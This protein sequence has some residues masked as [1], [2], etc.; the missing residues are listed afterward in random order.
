MTQFEGGKRRH[1]KEPPPIP[2]AHSV[3]RLAVRC[4]RNSSRMLKADEFPIRS[5]HKFDANRRMQIRTKVRRRIVCGQLK[6]T[7]TRCPCLA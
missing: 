6:N 4:H 1:I 5:E 2:E 7:Q 3:L